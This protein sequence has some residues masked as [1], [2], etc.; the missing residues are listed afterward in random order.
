[1]STRWIR[2]GD[3]NDLPIHVVPEADLRDHDTGPDG[4]CPCLPMRLEGGRIIRHNSYDRREVGE[5]VRDLMD[6]LGTA[7]ADHHHEWTPDEREAFEHVERIVDM[8]WP[9]PE[10]SF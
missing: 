8:H 10:P 1:M 7:L 9:P 4:L 6:A 3:E 2:L 5:V